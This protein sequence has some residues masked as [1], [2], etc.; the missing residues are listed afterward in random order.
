MNNR[1]ELEINVNF[2][3]ATEEIMVIVEYCQYGNLRDVLEKHHKNMKNSNTDNNIMQIQKSRPA[4][5][6]A[7]RPV[8]QKNLY[9]WAYQVAQGMQY[10]ASHNIV[11]GNLAARSVLLADGNIVKISDFGLARSM[12]KT[13]AYIA[14]KEVKLITMCLGIALV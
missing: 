4:A 11:H 7:A 3:F 6:G 5:F 10:I 1:F 12:Y 9:S 14:E 8:T 2:L 13:D